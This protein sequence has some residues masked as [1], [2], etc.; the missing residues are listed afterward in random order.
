MWAVVKTPDT[1][2]REALHVILAQG[3]LSASC[4]EF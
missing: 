3:L 1:R 2:L 4:N